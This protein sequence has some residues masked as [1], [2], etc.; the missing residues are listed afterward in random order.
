MKKQRIEISRGALYHNVKIIP[1]TH[2]FL[3]DY[4]KT[5]NTTIQVRI[6]EQTGHHSGRNRPPF[7]SKSATPGVR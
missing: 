7:R 4:A 6:P 1:A 3:V 5:T 2:I